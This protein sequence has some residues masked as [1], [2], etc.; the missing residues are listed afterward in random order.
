[1]KTVIKWHKTSEEMPQPTKYTKGNF[2]WE[3]DEPLLV[4]WKG[5]VKP[6]KWIPSE[7]YWEGHTQNQT[8][9]YW[10]YFKELIVEED[11]DAKNI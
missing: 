4:I 10:V 2:S 5:K 7:Q 8:P 6:S 3:V 11:D 1:M 9:P